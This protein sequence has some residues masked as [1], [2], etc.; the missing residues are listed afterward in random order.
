MY[1]KHVGKY[2]IVKTV[3]GRRDPF[4]NGVFAF[5]NNWTSVESVTILCEIDSAAIIPSIMDKLG[6]SISCLRERPIYADD[7]E[8]YHS[9]DTKI[10]AGYVPK[11]FV[12][13]TLTKCNGVGE[14]DYM[15]DICEHVERG[16]GKGTTTC[17]KRIYKGYFRL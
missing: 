14:P 15:M 7:K 12:E 17:K 6:D 2:T 5:F 16:I 13:V 3:D 11:D 4:L 1:K 9:E 8:I 10:M